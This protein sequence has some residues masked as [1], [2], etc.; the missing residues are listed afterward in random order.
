[1]VTRTT[2]TEPMY[3]GRTGEL[4]STPV[5]IGV[6]Y[7]QRLHHMVADKLHSRSRGPCAV[8]DQAAY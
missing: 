3:D 5:F 6:V 1:L 8:A 2:A 4:I 7:Y